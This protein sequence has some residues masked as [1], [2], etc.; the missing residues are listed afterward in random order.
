MRYELCSRLGA[1]LKAPFLLHLAREPV[2]QACHGCHGDGANL[3]TWTGKG[4]F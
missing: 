4:S 1:L 3:A 2:F